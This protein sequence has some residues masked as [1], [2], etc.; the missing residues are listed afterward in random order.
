MQIRSYMESNQGWNEI[1]V[2]DSGLF[3]KI[4]G[5]EIYDSKEVKTKEKF[6]KLLLSLWYWR[7]A[8]LVWEESNKCCR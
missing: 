5:E 3:V 4:K 7:C 8:N 6:R 2:A 1:G